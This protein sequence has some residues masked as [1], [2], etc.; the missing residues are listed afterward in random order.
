MAKTSKG[1]YVCLNRVKHDGKTFN[2]GAEIDLPEDQAKL[3]LAVKAIEKK[4]LTPE[5]KV[6]SKK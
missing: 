5:T 2:E 4:P 3:L 1:S 6:E